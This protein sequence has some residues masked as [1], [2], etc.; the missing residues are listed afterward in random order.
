MI[1]LLGVIIGLL[2]GVLVLLVEIYLTT[3]N[4]LVVKTI[5]EQIEKRVKENG[6]IF[7]PKDEGRATLDE[8]IADN[9]AAGRDTP[10]G[11]FV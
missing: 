3:R 7:E 8:H 4:R 11:N 6:E 2:V 5:T 10:M 9:E 1:F